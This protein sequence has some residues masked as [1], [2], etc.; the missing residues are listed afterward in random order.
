[1][2]TFICLVVLSCAVGTLYGGVYGCLVFG[3]VGL[4]IMATNKW[5]DWE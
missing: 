2:M 1:M 4:I 5:V 3:V